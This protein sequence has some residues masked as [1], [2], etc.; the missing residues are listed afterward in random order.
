MPTL[1]ASVDEFKLRQRYV[2]TD[3]DADI[4][5]VLQAASRMVLGYLK[6]DESYFAGSEYDTDGEYPADSDGVLINV[7]PEVKA[8]TIYLAGVL[9]RDPD[10]AE[11]EKWEL[12]YLPRPVLAMLYHLRDPA[13]Q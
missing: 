1:L 8:A 2:G 10:G 13:L 9:K 11:T 7:T 6:V 12:G 3:E 4:E 5:F